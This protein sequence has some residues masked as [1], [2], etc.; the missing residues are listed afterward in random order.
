MLR[1]NLFESYIESQKHE[2]FNDGVDPDTLHFISSLIDQN[3]ELVNKLE[4]VESLLNL[5]TQ[6]VSEVERQL[7]TAKVE[8]E[9]IIAEANQTAAKETQD[10]LSAATQQAQQIVEEAKEIKRRAE[11]ESN[12]MISETRQL[13]EAAKRQAEGIMN[14]AAAQAD[15]TRALAKQE[16]YKT[17]VDATKMAEEEAFRIRKKAEQMPGSNKKL[18]HSELIEPSEE[19][20]NRLYAVQEVVGHK[21]AI[22]TLRQEPTVKE[23]DLV[24]YEGAVDLLVQP[25]ITIDN[26]SK[27]VTHLK[28]TRGIDILNL[29]QSPNRG[30]CIRLRM[31]TRVPL[32]R[33]IKE[34]PEVEEVKAPLGGTDRMALSRRVGKVADGRSVSVR[35]RRVKPW[36]RSHEE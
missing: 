27:L 2:F 15:S 31:R 3:A 35:M 19:I 25:P 17:L 4:Q 13:A 11:V 6:R 32:L 10:K 23:E 20:H 8:A 18:R 21:Q 1:E 9:R 14:A 29:K 30:V 24:L 28:H 36:Y 16:A 7:E 22:N 5:M 33:I 12:K 34:A 26:V